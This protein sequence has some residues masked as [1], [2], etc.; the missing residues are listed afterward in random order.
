MAQLAVGPGPS[1]LTDCGPLIDAASVEKLEVL[2]EDAL[3]RNARVVT[4]GSR[5]D[6]LGY[7]YAP[8]VLDDVPHDA[9]IAQEEIFGPLAAVFGFETEDEAVAAA[10]DTDLGLAAYVCAG[11]LA[12]GLRVAE[13]LETGMVGVNR[14][15]VSDPAAP[16]GGWKQS[17]LGRE[18]GSHGL[19]EF[20]EVKYVAVSW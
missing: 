4:G 6:G 10:N 20:C 15:I 7:F 14:G 19:L 11:D 3:T 12:A 8:T 16:F 5:P 1:A 18:G 9:R 17:G 2:L 13:R